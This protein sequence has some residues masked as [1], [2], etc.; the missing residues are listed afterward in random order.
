[1]S[2]WPWSARRRRADELHQLLRDIRWE[3]REQRKYLDTF[4]HLAMRE[5]LA[6]VTAFSARQQ[7]GFESTLER[8]A[9]EQLS[10]ARFG[11]G[12]LRSMLRPEFN[13][14]FQPWSA[15][16]A[17]ELRSVL[18]YDGYDPGRLLLGFPYPY[19]SVHWSTVWTDIW[20]E[21]R[22]LLGTDR[23]YGSSHVSRPIFFHQVGEAGV[24]LWRKVWDGR[25]VCVV[26]GR[27]SRFS[28]PPAL[29]DGVRAI[30]SV[31]SEPVNAYADL[32][33][34]MTELEREDPEQLFLIA[35]GPTG[36]VVAAKLSALGRWAV[37]VGH[38][39]DSWANVFAGGP[40]PEEQDVRR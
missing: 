5:T 9:G 6:E 8:I 29:F 27:G 18:S 37:D 12:E 31:R 22:P 25:A 15:G 40:W 4:R 14:R 23:V 30:R 16:L 3:L 32:P 34:L 7:L 10:F 24:A 2:R 38:V 17:R 28:L 20:P 35:L 13:L 26:T 21:L 39:S 1:V 19:R 33:R 11:D 36:T